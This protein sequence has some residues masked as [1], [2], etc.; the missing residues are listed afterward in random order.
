MK[1][2][3]PLAALVAVAFSVGAQ[4]KLATYDWNV[5]QKTGQGAFSGSVVTAN[6]KSVFQIASTDAGLETRL[7]VI[8]NPPISKRIYAVT[9]RIKYED[10]SGD[11]YLEM[12]SYFPEGKFFSR[13]LADSGE[14]RKIHGTSDWREFS[15]PFDSTGSKG[16]PTHLEINIVLPGKG[17]VQFSSLQLLEYDSTNLRAFGNG[18]WWSDRSAGLIGGIGGSVIGC[19]GALLGWLTAKGRARRFVVMSIQ[20]MAALGI[21]LTVV[22]LIALGLKQP[23]AVWYPLLLGGILLAATFFN[24]P[25]LRRRYDELE[26]RRMNS[27]DAMAS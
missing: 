4:Q 24:L 19:F 12:W 13:T 8:S 26:L 5:M 17:N 16:S 21:L 1:I 14:M 6:N 3:F 22:G 11:G 2:Q 7:L 27:M 10:V 20:T 25:K 15:L 9:G 18:G 23:Y